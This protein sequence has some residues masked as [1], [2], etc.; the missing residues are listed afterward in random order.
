MPQ[1][2]KPRVTAGVTSPKAK[3]QSIN[4]QSFN[5]NGVSIKWKIIIKSKNNIQTNM[6]YGY[7][8]YSSQLHLYPIFWPDCAPCIENIVKE[9]KGCLWILSFC[10]ISCSRINWSMETS[11]LLE[12]VC[13]IEPYGH[14]TG[15]IF[16][17]VEQIVTNG[18][19]FFW[20]Y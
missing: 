10:F 18:H 13:K 8:S 15:R 11:P 3:G 6:W 19:R 4:L 2:P 17:C 5:G 16:Y 7:T 12:K 20:S 9:N 1:K 14:W